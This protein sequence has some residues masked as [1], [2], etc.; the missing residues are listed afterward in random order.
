MEKTNVNLRQLIDDFLEY[1]EVEKAVSPLTIRDYKIYLTKFINWLIENHVLLFPS[2]INLE[3]IRDYRLFLA[4]LTLDNG[5]HL[6]KVTQSYYVIALR[7]LLRYLIVNRDIDTLNPDK[8]V[9]PKTAPRMIEYLNS[10]QI[11]RLLNSPTVSNVIGLRDKAILETL[12]STGLRVS[13]LAKLNRD[14]INFDRQ[15]FGVRGKGNKVRIVFLS[16]PASMWL[17]R[18]ISKRNDDYCPL[19]IRYSRGESSIKRG[20]KMRLSVRSIER[21]VTKYSRKCGLPFDAHPHTLRHTFATDLLIGGADIRSV[22]EMLGHESLITT[23]IYTHVTNKQLKDVHQK[24]HRK[25]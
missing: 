19:F 20:E 18:Y 24:F 9:L 17:N 2:S 22:Q 4:H 11:E 16:D 3:L 10:E 13:E 6:K 8:I 14:Q 7:S 25:K 5:Q 15:E 1:L 21:V 12:F 23:Q